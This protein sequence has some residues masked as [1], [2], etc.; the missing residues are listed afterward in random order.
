MASEKAEK[1]PVKVRR[2]TQEQTVERSGW[3]SAESQTRQAQPKALEIRE[4]EEPRVTNPESTID[5]I[6]RCLGGD[7]NDELAKEVFR[8]LVRMGSRGIR[9]RDIQQKTGVTQGAVVYHLNTF[10]RRGLIIKNGRYYYLKRQTL[11]RTLEEMENEM[12]RHFERM[13][14]FAKMIEEE[15]EGF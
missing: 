15:M 11:D 12:L 3:E 6:F 8:E 1:I 2:R 9:S 4:I 10:M 5:W 13:R 7:D 14:R